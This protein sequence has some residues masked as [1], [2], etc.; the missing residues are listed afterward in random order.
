MPA[1]APAAILPGQVIDGP[2][3]DIKSFGDVDMAPDGTGGLVYLK[4]V[5]GVN[6]VFVASYSNGTWRNPQQVDTAPIIQSKIRRWPRIAAANGG[7]L[8][9]TFVSGNG[10]TGS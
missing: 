3:A 7:R 8:I 9:V 5:A 10:A 6:H 2:S 4:A 1:G